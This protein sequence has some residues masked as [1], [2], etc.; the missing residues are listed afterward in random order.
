MKRFKSSG[1]RLKHLAAALQCLD[2]ILVSQQLPTVT[3]EQFFYFSKTFF[4]EIFCHWSIMIWMSVFWLEGQICRFVA[5]Q[6]Q[7][8]S[9]TF[10]RCSHCMVACFCD[11][12]NWTLLN[13][14]IFFGQALLVSTGCAWYDLNHQGMLLYISVNF[15]KDNWWIYDLSKHHSLIWNFCL[16][17][18]ICSHADHSDRIGRKWHAKELMLAKWHWS[19]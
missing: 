4:L 19:S 9:K 8:L 12:S 15:W 17:H 11:W 5:V 13:Q 3:T 16:Q 7:R 6:E 10:L 2:L 18:H 1:R 14:T